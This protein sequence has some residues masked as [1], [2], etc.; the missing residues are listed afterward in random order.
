MNTGSLAGKAY[1]VTG[2][3]RGIGLALA[4]AMGRRGARVALFGRDQAALAQGAAAAGNGS[5]YIAL[6]LGERD[7]LMAAVDD[8]A[9]QLGGL[10]GIVNN[11]GMALASKIEALRPADVATQVNINFLAQ[12]YGCQAAIPHLRRRGGGRIMNLSSVTV[13][14]LDEF[15]FIAIYSATKAAVERFSQELRI[16]VK[17]D[18]IGVT[19]FRPGSTSTSFGS[20]QDP[21]IMGEAFKEWLDRAEMYD[22]TLEAETVAE[23]MVRCFELPEGANIDLVELNPN[24]LTPRRRTLE[25]YAERGNNP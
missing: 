22:G 24:R 5:F 23:A 12:V 2:A 4:K 9:G 3:S 13:G 18:N 8:A 20:G 6:D 11:A 25:I 17:K 14:H 19:V 16:E 10:D 1:I 15:A 21:A 7:A